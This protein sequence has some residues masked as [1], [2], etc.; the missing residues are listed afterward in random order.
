MATNYSSEISHKSICCHSQTSFLGLPLLESYIESQA[1]IYM[2]GRKLIL[3]SG[4]LVRLW[5]DPW[6]DSSILKTSYPMLFDI[7]NNQECT[8]SSFVANGCVPS[9]RRR[10]T[11]EL[12]EQWNKIVCGA[13]SLALNG[14]PDKVIWSLNNSGKFLTKSVY[15]WLEKPLAGA[16]YGWIWKAPLPLK[17]KIHMWQLFCNA[18]LTRDK[19]KKR[20]WTGNL[21][22]SFCNV[23]EDAQH[24][25]FGCGIA[26]SVWGTIGRVLGTDS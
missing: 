12:Y 6:L 17:I 24:L 4:D 7:R 22:C 5:H 14:S 10:L 11:P 13:R 9:F 2:E 18:V 1:Y 25:F 19:L 26:K 20:K 16:H 23:P 8:L 15:K 3:N 21:M